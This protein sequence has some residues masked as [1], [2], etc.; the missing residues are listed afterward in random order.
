M[1]NL[2]KDIYKKR[3]KYQR[4]RDKQDELTYI[5]A[6]KALT[7]G[8]DK[9]QR[10]SWK[11][12]INDK[13]LLYKIVLEKIPVGEVMHSIAEKSRESQSWKDLAER[14]LNNLIPDDANYCEHTEESINNELA[15][16]WTED[17]V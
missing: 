8:V 17:E 6:K 1:T 16:E 2:K 3:K 4:T 14:L 10:K 13:V 15:Q 12:F 7:R 9:T 5:E 11:D